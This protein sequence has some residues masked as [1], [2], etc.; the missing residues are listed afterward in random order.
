MASSTAAMRLEVKTPDGTLF[1]V[2]RPLP[3]NTVVAIGLKNGDI[4]LING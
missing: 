1:V 2:E 4:A 3:L